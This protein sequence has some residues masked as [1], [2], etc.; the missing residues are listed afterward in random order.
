M[1]PE[2]PKLALVEGDIRHPI[3]WEKKVGTIDT[4][5]NF[6]AESHVDN[7]IHGPRKFFD[8]NILGVASMIEFCVGNDARLHQVSTDEVFG[9]MLDTESGVADEASPYRP[10]NP[11]SASKASGDL[12]ILAAVRT[13]G[14]K[15]TISYGSNTYG[16]GQHPEKLIPKLANQ[17]LRGAPMTLYGDGMEIRD[18]ITASD[19][20]K[21]ILACLAYGQEGETYCLP[22]NNE[23]ANISLARKIAESL[24]SPGHPTNFIDDRPGHDRKYK[25][26]GLKAARD[27]SWSPSSVEMNLDYL[28]KA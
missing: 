4:V 28:R 6:A 27:L 5:V 14:L 15:A 12:L 7:S 17:V 8:T 10:S 26:S 25:M 16:P 20:C 11:Y 2:N 3:K 13:F 22:G 9:D 19:H 23:M 1:L 21:G 18:W 24:G